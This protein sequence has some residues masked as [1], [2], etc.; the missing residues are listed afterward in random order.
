MDEMSLS[1]LLRKC[2]E[3][4]H[5]LFVSSN[6]VHLRQEPAIDLKELV[7]LIDRFL[8]GPMRYEMEWDD[9]ISWENDNPHI[10]EV[11]KRI[12][13]FEPLLFSTNAAD[14]EIYGEKLT[15][16]RNRVAA[17]LGLSLRD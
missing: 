16:E 12:S 10:E 3:K 13:Q 15:E 8:D 6:R 17:L 11:R 7:G 5:E 9:F 1:K 4:M 2:G 14:R